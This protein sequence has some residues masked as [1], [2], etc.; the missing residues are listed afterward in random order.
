MQ[1]TMVMVMSVDGFVTQGEDGP[2]FAWASE[3]DREVFLERL[4][5]ADAVITGRSSF[6]GGK[7][8]PRPYYVL[9]S[10]ADLPKF[11][12]VFHLKGDAR[13]IAEC[14]KAD[15]HEDVVLLGGPQTNAQFL[16]AGLVDKVMLTVEPRLFGTGK[17]LSLGTK[18]NIPMRLI[19][20]KRL[21]EQGTLLLEY[22]I[23]PLSSYR[24]DRTS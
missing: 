13:S 2:S 19:N 18:F 12:N 1:I 7:D 17:P 20:E 14:V 23:L 10:R 21:N 8:M 11:K 9:T 22:E 15:G 5:K 24:K 4:R 6:V 16:E 3:A